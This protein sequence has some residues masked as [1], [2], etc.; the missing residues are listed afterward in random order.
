MSKDNLKENIN[1]LKDSSNLQTPQ[2]LISQIKNNMNTSNELSKY[3]CDHCPAMEWVKLFMGFFTICASFSSIM[4][5]F[6]WNKV[7]EF[8]T[9]FG[10]LELSHA[11]MI[12]FI[13][14]AITIGITYIFGNI[15]KYMYK[16]IL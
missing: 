11:I 6:S 15:A 16:K 8:L 2:D 9:L 5:Y 14:I 13:T 10:T 4:I 3:S 1:A 7:I 12:T